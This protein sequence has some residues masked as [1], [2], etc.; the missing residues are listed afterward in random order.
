M[1]SVGKIKPII[2]DE[3]TGSPTSWSWDVDGD[4]IEDYNTQNP[5]HVYSSDGVYTVNLTVSNLCGSD[6]E[7]KVGYITVNPVPTASFSANITSGC[8]P[9]VVLF[10]D[11]S[12]GSPVS[13]SWDVDGDGVEDYNTQ[14][15]THSYGSSGIYTVRLRVSTGSCN[16]WENKTNYI[17]V[18]TSPV[19]S[20]SANVTVGSAPL[21]V[22]FTDLSTGV[23]ILWSW[24]VDG[25]GIEDYNTQNPVHVYSTIGIYTVN[26]TTTNDCGSDWENKT[27]YI[28]VVNVT[29]TP[30]YPPQDTSDGIYQMTSSHGETWIRWNWVIPPAKYGNNTNISII[31]DDEILYNMS[32]L[33]R[34]GIT[35]TYTSSDLN[36]DEMHT[37][38]LVEY[39]DA[40]PE[41]LYMISSDKLSVMTD[42]SLVYYLFFF[43]VSIIMMAIGSI[44]TNHI[45]SVVFVTVSFLISLYIVIS[46]YKNNII[47]SGVAT[48]LALVAGFVII[49]I[50]YDLYKQS[51]GWG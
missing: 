19:T 13:W 32:L 45:K 50:L 42:H 26:L 22:A 4:T 11:S 20:F 39:S 9:L 15:A 36:T 8:L 18:T 7:N 24:D 12:T 43:V 30:T 41:Y 3:S 2:L 5:S 14:N 21:A 44:M 10:T 38:T 33:N 51:R 34:N 1:E 31:L 25:D 48:I 6:S 49:Y 17:S 23:P 40:N 37:L 16:D 28:T 47:I 35:T 46:T 29:P 27:S